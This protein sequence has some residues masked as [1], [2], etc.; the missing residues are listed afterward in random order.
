MVTE[1]VL[2]RVGRLKEF[3]LTGRF[4][5]ANRE[6]PDRNRTSA[7]ARHLK[8]ELISVLAPGQISVPVTTTAGEPAHSVR[9]QRTSAHD[10]TKE[11]QDAK[12]RACGSR[13]W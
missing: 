7:R 2:T 8:D 11:E 10:Q 12:A 3:L 6:C 5:Q 4:L 9:V 13:R 1:T